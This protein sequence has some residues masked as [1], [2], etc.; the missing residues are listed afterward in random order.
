MSQAGYT[1]IQLYFSTTAAAVP[2]NTNLANG[3]LAINI[4]DGKLYYK[5]NGGTV[6]LL[7]SN[8][9]SAPVL[10]F[11]A[12]TTGFTP[13][14]ATTGA[15]TLA[16]TLAT[17]NGG[18][19]LSSFTSG[20]VVYASS[21]SALATG[22][23]L[24]FDGTKLSVGS[25]ASTSAGLTSGY[26]GASGY[27]AI[28]STGVTPST[29]NFAFLTNGTSTVING[30][31]G[32][33]I[34]ANNTDVVNIS[35]VGV[36]INTATNVNNAK[37]KSKVT[38]GGTGL[39]V[40]DEASSDFVVVPGVSSGVCK[41]GPTAGTMAF[42][43]AG[44]EGM[45]LTSTGLGIGTSS[46]NRLLSLYATQ[47]VFQI[48]N[49]AS[50]NTQGTIQYQASGGT[51]FVLDN[52]GSGSGGNIIFQQAGTER[53][54][55]AS[56]GAFGLS[57]ANY[58]TSG[59]VL[60]SGG[61]GAAPTWTTVGG[62]GGSAAT[63]TVSGTVFGT[64]SGASNVGIGYAA[65]TS[66]TTGTNNTVMGYN[67]GDDITT[68]TYNTVVGWSAYGAVSTASYNVAIG[69]LALAAN[70]S[71]A[72]NVAVGLEALSANTTANNN[73]A[74]G[75]QAL[76]L[77]TTGTQNVAIGSGAL[78]TNTT[79]SRNTAVGLNALNLSTAAD[80]TAMGFTAGAS[81]STGVK[82][83]AIGS[84][85]LVANTTGSNS[86]AVGY[87]ALGAQTTGLN[88]VAI[89]YLA[90]AANTTGDSQVAIGYTALASATTGSQNTAI[91]H[92]TLLNLTTSS[93]NTAAG[94]RA[95]KTVVTGS[96]NTAFGLIA[97]TANTGNFNT[98]VGSSALAANTTGSTN[99]AVGYTSL[100]AC[101]TGTNN[102]A[103]GSG[104]L[105]G[106]TTGTGNVGIGLNAASALT[107]GAENIVIGYPQGFGGW[108]LSTGSYNV[109]I[110]VRAGE[111]V[112]TSNNNICLGY[113]A[114]PSSST[115]TQQLVIGTN[116]G[117]T[118]KGNNTGFIDPNGGPVYQG[119]NSSS[120]STTS[121]QRL[122][123]NIVDNNVGLTAINS[124][125]VRN[126]EYRVGDEITELPTH[127]AIK[128]EGVQLGVI[129]Q[130]LQAVLPNCVKI[131]STGVLS[132][133]TDN[134]TWY[135][136]NA[137]KEL[138]AQNDSLQA[139]LDAANL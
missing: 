135:L 47:P 44:T 83:T 29:T 12:G 110:G 2:V 98:A 28:W 96:D 73:V 87:Q 90:F 99:T 54:R 25:G 22:S 81:I 92:E 16:G 36:L 109:F 117:S 131:E 119:N 20:G 62:G 71:G 64:T 78:Q 129:A 60:T 70:T 17:T 42:Q 15:I 89:G 8:A 77:N 104:S 101:T 106:V 112:T 88:N 80:N 37:L 125:R 10:S 75:Y 4:T 123:K 84:Y 102:S 48:T 40:T 85:A 134:L 76:K 116:Y 59:Q 58:G 67:A 13:S 100:D 65:L 86:T 32:V 55:I 18:T 133:D 114:N 113:Y 27:G 23:V 115:G 69:A 91:G 72:N 34:Q 30:S 57:G 136:I 14:T 26:F 137:V 35:T 94:F 49:V 51:D 33:T 5:D 6:R 66:I 138:K 130:E 1:P 53:L 82:N 93:G 124:I 11:S 21:S 68:G 45:R 105:G 52:Q 139:R 127:C 121:D 56:T 41:I 111:V 97:L 7:A 128:K 120:W 39:E 31:S 43:Q 108:A 38:A 122:K 103:L 132:V 63:P 19:G 9:T 107:T 46:P 95:L 50:G 126:F 24:S 61:S 74:A 79:S 3:E 118:G